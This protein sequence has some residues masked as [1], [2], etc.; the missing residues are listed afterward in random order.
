LRSFDRT[1]PEEHNRVLTDKITDHFFI[2]EQSG[3]DN[4]LREGGTEGGR[5]TSWA[6]P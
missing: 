2:T 3:L 1:M 6:T 4:L 5:C